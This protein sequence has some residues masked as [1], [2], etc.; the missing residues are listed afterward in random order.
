MN[1]RKINFQQ[2]GDERG[3]LVALEEMREVPFKIR[4]VYYMYKTLKGVTRG[5]SMYPMAISFSF[6][7][8]N[9]PFFF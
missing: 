5:I 1:I 9:T 7:I 3:E 6:I 2:H 4:R 8:V